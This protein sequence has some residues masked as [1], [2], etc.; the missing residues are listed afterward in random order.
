M[1]R[2]ASVKARPGSTASRSPTLV[3]PPGRHMLNKPCRSVPNAPSDARPAGG[4]RRHHFGLL[5]AR[6]H[7]FFDRWHSGGE[8]I[9]EGEGAGPRKHTERLV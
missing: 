7:P 5:F 8:N 9:D 6:G 1:L 2:S 4:E 3:R